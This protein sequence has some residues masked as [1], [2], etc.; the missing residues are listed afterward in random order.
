MEWVEGKFRGL[1]MSCEA[2]SVS[3]VAVEGVF[4]E[5]E[6][7]RRMA[8]GGDPLSPGTGREGGMEGGRERLTGREVTVVAHT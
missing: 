7:Q 3:R 4:E 1:C 8:G 6:G 2:S 5:E